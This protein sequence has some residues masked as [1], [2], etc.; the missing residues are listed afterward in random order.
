MFNQHFDFHDHVNNVII[1]C[2]QCLYALKTLMSKGLQGHSLNIVC[3][4]TFLSCLTDASPSWWG[5]LTAQDLFRLQGV[6]NKAKRWE[7][8]GKEGLPDLSDVYQQAD[9][10]LFK[11]ILTNPHHVLHKCLPPVK[12]H[13]YN[14]RPRQHNRVIPKSNALMSKNFLNRMLAKDSY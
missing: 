4:S 6:V 12:D 8:E 14:L 3:K 11:S 10:G 9:S 5:F 1:K 7:C 13:N 2:S